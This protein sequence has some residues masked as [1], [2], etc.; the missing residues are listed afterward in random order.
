MAVET[1]STPE[2][3]GLEAD[4]DLGLFQR[5]QEGLPVE[6][7]DRLQEFGDL[8]DEEFA[9]I[10]PRRTES[11]QRERKRLSKAQSDRVVLAALVFARAHRVFGNREKANR[12]MTRKHASLGGKRPIDLLRTSTGAE[13]VREVLVR[14]EHGVYA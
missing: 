4:S 7:L 13:L 1:V 6:T 8:S 14:I 11:Y 12:W 10:I 9:A 2:V 3:L 5:V